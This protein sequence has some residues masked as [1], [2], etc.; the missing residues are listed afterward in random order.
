MNM[1]ALAEV[2]FALDRLRSCADL[3]E[4]VA[5]VG[6]PMQ[7][8]S[9]ETIAEAIRLFRNEAGKFLHEAVES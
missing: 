9:L 5:N 7:E 1:E 3:I 6:G 8:R 4:A 2:A